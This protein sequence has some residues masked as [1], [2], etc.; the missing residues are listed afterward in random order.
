M[1][2]EADITIGLSI[3]QHYHSNNEYR[4]ERSVSYANCWAGIGQSINLIFRIKMNLQLYIYNY[5]NIA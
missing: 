5:D 1:S 3:Q 4:G 2:P